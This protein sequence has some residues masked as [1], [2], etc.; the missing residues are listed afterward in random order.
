[1]ILGVCDVDGSHNILNIDKRC[2]VFVEN[3]FSAD[4]AVRK[5]VFLQAAGEDAAAREQGMLKFFL[6][7]VPLLVIPASYLSWRYL[8]FRKVRWCFYALILIA[9]FILNF[10]QVSFWNGLFDA[11]ELMLVNFIC[12]EFFWNLLKVKNRQLFRVVFLIA[13][14]AYGFEFRHWLAAGPNHAA[15]LWDPPAADTFRRGSD[16]YAVREYVLYASIIPAR[17]V[18]LWKR[19]GKWPFEKQIKSYRTPAGFGDAV[20]SYQWSETSDGVRLDLHAAGYRLWT[21]GEGF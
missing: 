18:V 13:L 10:M 11:V 4:G 17:S 14:C 16:S 21:M 9:A 5:N 15:K 7:S 20:I 2:A 3:G 1:M 12:A 8:P 6:W 19:L